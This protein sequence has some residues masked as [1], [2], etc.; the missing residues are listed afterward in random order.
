MTIHLAISTKREKAD[1]GNLAS[2]PCAPRVHAGRADARPT[3]DVRVGGPDI[4]AALRNYQHQLP[5]TVAP[6]PVPTEPTAEEPK[7]ILDTVSASRKVGI[8]TQHPEE[9]VQKLTAVVYHLCEGSFPGY[10]VSNVHKLVLVL[11]IDWE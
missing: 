7:T 5:R 9:L 4:F 6:G 3:A 2:A 1:R 10:E 11:L 8:D